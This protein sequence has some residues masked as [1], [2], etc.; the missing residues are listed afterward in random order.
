MIKSGNVKN[1]W[2]LLSSLVCPTQM[3]ACAGGAHN[4][5]AVRHTSIA[6][7]TENSTTPTKPIN[8]PTTALAADAADSTAAPSPAVE[9]RPNGQII[10]PNAL[11]ATR[12]AGDLA[13][14]PDEATTIEITKAAAGKISGT[15]KYCLDVTGAV[16]SV[17]VLKSIGFPAYD[18]TLMSTM[19]STW[20]FHPFMVRGQPA[21]VCSTTTFV[22]EPAA[23]VVID[24]KL[25]KRIA[26]Y[27]LIYPNNALAKAI[28]QSGRGKITGNFKFCISTQGRVARVELL[29]STGFP[30]Y[31]YGIAKTML[32]T[33]RYSP[34]LVDGQPAPV[35]STVT[36][37][38]RIR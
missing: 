21:P 6:P 28:D 11:S 23:P 20:R 36:F 5:M 1:R 4:A 34:Y 27:S 31:D 3:S 29:A 12:T 37:I 15:F 25:F 14:Q 7:R 2:L 8:E 19:R 16:D 13:I 38:Y 17:T 10:A 18:Q 24:I 9:A 30:A 26:G 35:C 32:E 22:Y 33:W